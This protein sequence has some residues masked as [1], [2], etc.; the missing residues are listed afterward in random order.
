MFPVCSCTCAHCVW[1]NTYGVRIQPPP[2]IY[3]DY[4][5]YYN[6]LGV[7]QQTP[8]ISTP[9]SVT[10]DCTTPETTPKHSQSFISPELVQIFATGKRKRAQERKKDKKRKKKER[11][12]EKKKATSNQPSL[13]NT[14]NISYGER[15]DTITKLQSVLDSNYDC[16]IAKNKPITFP[17]VPLSQYK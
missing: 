15:N 12:K 4:N 14:K 2:P 6:Y 9:P 7:Q 8:V 3:P 16:Y 5:P 17:D 1:Q 11:Q 10:Q 13:E